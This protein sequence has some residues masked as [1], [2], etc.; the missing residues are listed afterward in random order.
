MS[1]TMQ[2]RMPPS[3]VDTPARGLYIHVASGSRSRVVLHQDSGIR[4]SRQVQVCR[5]YYILLVDV[6][7]FFNQLIFLEDSSLVTNLTKRIHLL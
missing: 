5:R 7:A 3:S 4:L 2:M 6:N 1:S